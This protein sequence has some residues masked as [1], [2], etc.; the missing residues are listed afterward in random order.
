SEHLP[1]YQRRYIEDAFQTRVFD[2]YGC[3]EI[4]SVGYECERHDGYHIPEEHVVVETLDDAQEDV[5]GP[6]RGPLVITDLDNFYMPLIR[7]RNGDAGALTEEPC[8]CGR[9]LRR[10]A[11]LYGRVSDL[12]RSTDGTL[13]YGGIVDYVL[14]K[15][16]HVREFC[17]IQEQPT[18]CRLQYV[19]EETDDEI[20]Q[21]VEQLRQ[22]LGQDM[23]IVTEAVPRIPLT[24]SGKRRF[25]M[26]RLN[27]A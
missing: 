6:A 16:K 22:F 14:G 26:S 4:T 5:R 25:T 27:D 21:V 23:T 24:V 18:L 10:I 19:M 8:G 13:V 1:Q 17:L 3:V 2:Y 7:Y 11:P 12:L 20:P 15:T 9:T